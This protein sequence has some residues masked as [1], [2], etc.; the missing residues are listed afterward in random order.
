MII[1]AP[2]S[3]TS[4][5]SVLL[6][7]DASGLDQLLTC[8][9][10][11][12]T[13]YGTLALLCNF[14]EGTKIAELCQRHNLY[15]SNWSLLLFHAFNIINLFQME[16]NPLVYVFHTATN[17]ISKHS[18]RAMTS[19]MLMWAI[20]HRSVHFFTSRLDG[21]D[22]DMKSKTRHHTSMGVWIL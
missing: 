5:N 18:A 22:D 16:S 15:V 11:C 7:G 1:A 19:Y 13:P 6:H 9:E 8:A 2:P 4:F 12:L 14:S 21:D 20:I 10:G 17:P 3:A